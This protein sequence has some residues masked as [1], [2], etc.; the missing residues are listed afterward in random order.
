MDLTINLKT[1]RASC[2]L[3]GSERPV[4]RGPDRPL[5][6]HVPKLQHQNG[7]QQLVS[8]L[9]G[10]YQSHMCELHFREE[11]LHMSMQ[12]WAPAQL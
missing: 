5:F 3:H 11:C 8:D 9:N 2:S 4:T 12:V 6:C 1:A 10:S 7:F